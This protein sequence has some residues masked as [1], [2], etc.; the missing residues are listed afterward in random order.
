MRK[1]YLFKDDGRRDVYMYVCLF[2]GEEGKM[3]FRA[4]HDQRLAAG[5][6]Q[7]HP[8]LDPRKM[9]MH[10]SVWVGGFCPLLRWFGRSGFSGLEKF[11][12][13]QAGI[14]GSV[15]G[16]QSFEAEAAGGDR[17][18]EVHNLGKRV[19]SDIV[20]RPFGNR[21]FDGFRS[22]A[23]QDPIAEDGAHIAFR[24]LRRCHD[25]SADPLFFPGVDRDPVGIR[26]ILSGQP[27]FAV[28]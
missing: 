19:V 28:G 24:R 1:T 15:G 8:V 25:Q 27:E 3:G 26:G 12:P 7:G 10:F 13:G 20:E 16:F 21:G 14:A 23:D 4:A 18:W 5:P 17:G 9:L 6:R 11:D 22:V 2:A